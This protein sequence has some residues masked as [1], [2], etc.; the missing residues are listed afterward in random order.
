MSRLE[1]HVALLPSLRETGGAVIVIDVLRATTSLATA[2]AAGAAEVVVCGSLRAA[3]DAATA[4]ER[5]GARPLLFGES[6]SR[7]PK[8]FDFGN[9]PAELSR[10]VLRGRVMVCATT[11]GTRALQSVRGAEAAFAGSLVNREAALRAAVDGARSGRL[12]FVCAGRRAGSR[13]ALEDVVAAGGFVDLVRD[14][15]VHLTD[16]AA[17]AVGL[18]QA[19]GGDAYAAFRDA[20]HG[21]H[22]EALGFGE[23]LRFAARLDVFGVAPRLVRRD[24]RL[25]LVP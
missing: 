18:W 6:R 23:D 3:R 5:A 11:N 4:L 1:V 22:L 14:E 7:R 16:E 21:R 9:S 20:A 19:Y 12:T 25:S 2:F 8:G 10:A 15:G 24:G 13:V 17:L